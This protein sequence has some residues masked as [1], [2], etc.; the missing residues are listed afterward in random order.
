M[1]PLVMLQVFFLTAFTVAFPFRI[2]MV[3]LDAADIGER[4]RRA[5]E[6]R[7]AMFLR[8]TRAELLAS[9]PAAL[10]PPSPGGLA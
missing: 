4:A 5:R 7:E 8:D 3:M 6:L 2:W 10:P 1:E 9:L